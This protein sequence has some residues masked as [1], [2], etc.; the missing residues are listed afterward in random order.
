ML[1]K[2]RYVK[3]GLMALLLW[4]T[5][6]PKVL[7]E[8]PK[9]QL[10][11]TIDRVM[12]VI[13]TP[14]RAN[15]MAQSR[16]LLRQVLLRRFDLVEMARRSLGR[17]WNRLNGREEEFLIAFAQF[18]EGSYM[19]TLGSYRGEKIVYGREQV[20]KNLAEVDTQVLDPQG[21]A[22]A[23][24]YRLH[25]VSGEWKVY[26]MVIDHV[27]LVSNYQSQFS[28]ILRTA[29]LDELLRKLREKREGMQG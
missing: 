9:Q 5:P 8:T 14:Q 15:D 1:A 19:S 28:R 12:E 6:A 10:Q 29:P 26:D 17:H 16:E 18:V 23:V 2:N 24:T 25:L 27:S 13:R 3:L 11:G 22:T 4:W 7:A 21:D 20:N